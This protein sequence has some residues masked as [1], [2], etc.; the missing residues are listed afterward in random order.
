[1]PETHAAGPAAVVVHA[2]REQPSVMHAYWALSTPDTT[3]H[4]RVTIAER[5]LDARTLAADAPRR[6]NWPAVRLGVMAALLRNKFDRHPAMAT[7][8][9]ATGVTRLLHTDWGSRYWSS[10]GTNGL[11][12]LLELI[13]SE[14]IEPGSERAR[15]KPR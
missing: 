4:D 1:M 5:G 11:G 3:W 9:L 10:E 15:R 13:R 8:L 6:D 14:L 2:G 7:E 12:R